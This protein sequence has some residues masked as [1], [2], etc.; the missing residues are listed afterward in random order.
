MIVFY[1]GVMPKNI[2]HQLIFP[3]GYNVGL[4]NK[5]FRYGLQGRQYGSIVLGLA[6]VCR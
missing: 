2:C 4:L 1:S 3:Q 5:V 6:T